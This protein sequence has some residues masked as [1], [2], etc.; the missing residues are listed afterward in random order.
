VLICVG[1][2]IKAACSSKCHNLALEA[3]S[4]LFKEVLESLKKVTP[5]SK[6]LD[7]DMF[8]NAFE[9]DEDTLVK[10]QPFI[11]LCD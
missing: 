11:N 8:E 4:K 6:S 3:N 2:S 5:L 9:D 1:S 7:M 10:D